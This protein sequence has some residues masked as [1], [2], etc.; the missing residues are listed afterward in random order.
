EG[1]CTGA[2][3]SEWHGAEVSDGRVVKLVLWENNLRGSIPKELGQLSALQELWL[4]SNKL[5]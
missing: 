2:P 4:S 5:G 3:L 1:W